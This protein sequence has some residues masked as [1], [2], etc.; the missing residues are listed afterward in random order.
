MPEGLGPAVSDWR[1]RPEPLPG[2]AG[3]T[4]HRHVGLIQVA[5]DRRPTLDLVRLPGIEPGRHQAPYVAGFLA[6]LDMMAFRQG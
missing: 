1:M 6:P 5:I 4:H 2:L 3:W